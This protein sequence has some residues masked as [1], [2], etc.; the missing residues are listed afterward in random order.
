MHP[1]FI[2]STFSPPIALACRPA[3]LDIWVLVN[4]VRPLS[5]NPETENK[6]LGFVFVER[7]APYNVLASCASSTLCLVA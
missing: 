4:L 2:R 6:I 7:L 5:E 1:L 3:L